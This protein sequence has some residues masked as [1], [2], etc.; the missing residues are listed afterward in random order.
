LLAQVEKT[1]ARKAEIEAKYCEPGFFEQTAEAQVEKLKR[2]QMEIESR[3]D[4]LM[5][6]WESVEAELT[7]L[8]LN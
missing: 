7:D 3:L 6:E 2:E 4:R 5:T 1:E 8:G